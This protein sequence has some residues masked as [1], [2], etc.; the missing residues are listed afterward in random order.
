ME[1]TDTSISI[2]F[3][4]SGDDSVPDDVKS[5]ASTVNTGSWVWNLVS[6]FHYYL[7]TSLSQ[8]TP[9]A[10]F[11]GTSCDI[12]SHF[13]PHNIIINLTFCSYSTPYICM[14]NLGCGLG[15]DWAGSVY[16]SSGC[17]STCVGRY[18][19]QLYTPLLI[20]DCYRLCR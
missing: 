18:L 5:A 20:C 14:T 2:Y 8:G 3:W 17:P 16:G 15:G 9:S 13:G 6:S 11:P 4:A 7:P 12:P 19:P 1:R 10:F